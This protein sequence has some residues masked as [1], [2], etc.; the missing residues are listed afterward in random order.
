MQMAI[1]QELTTLGPIAA[2]LDPAAP[3]LGALSLR[4]MA[5][6]GLSDTQ[7]ARYFRVSEERVVSLK[8]YYGLG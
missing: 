1:A 8:R 3:P 5:D 6:L 2:E 4:I 7:I